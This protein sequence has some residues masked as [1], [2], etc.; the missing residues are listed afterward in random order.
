VKPDLLNR[1]VLDFLAEQRDPQ[2]MPPVRRV[3]TSQR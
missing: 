2:T 1:I 3:A